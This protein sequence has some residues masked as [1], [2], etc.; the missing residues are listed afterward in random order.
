MSSIYQMLLPENLS[1]EKVL[2]GISRKIAEEVRPFQK[3]GAVAAKIRDVVEAMLD[4]H[5]F[6]FKNCGLYDVCKHNVPMAW[7][8]PNQAQAADKP[9]HFIH[10]W[11]QNGIEDLLTET[12]PTILEESHIPP[13]SEG[14]VKQ[15]LEGILKN[16][17]GRYLF[18]NET[19]VHADVCKS[20]VQGDPWKA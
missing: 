9:R 8:S 11:F 10:V 20:N 6:H 16:E 1:L 3:S 14:A 7:N 13:K 2:D 17:L 18:E 15:R 12:V 19:C 4:K 5:T